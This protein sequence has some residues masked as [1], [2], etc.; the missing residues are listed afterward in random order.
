MAV[1]LAIDSEVREKK[2]IFVIFLSDTDGV[3][4]SPTES[5]FF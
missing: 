1:F 3:S 5:D 2:P 4:I